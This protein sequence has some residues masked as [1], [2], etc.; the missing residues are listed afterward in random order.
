LPMIIN[1]SLFNT[2][3]FEQPL[4]AIVEYTSGLINKSP[5]NL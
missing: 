3:L 1:A 5:A 2:W 4:T